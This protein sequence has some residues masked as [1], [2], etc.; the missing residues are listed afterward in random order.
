MADQ[1]K[2]KNLDQILDSLLA[3]Y[4]DV[5]PRPGLETRIVAK[6]RDHANRSN[7]W[8][9]K[10]AWTWSG[11]AVAA[12]AVLVLIVG[13]ELPIELPRQPVFHADWSLLHRSAPAVV[14]AARVN[15]KR[16]QTHEENAVSIATADTRPEVFP[17]PSPL[18]DQ[19][20]LMLRYL[21]R[22]TKQEIIAQ[23]HPDKPLETE[24]PLQ[25]P[26]QSPAQTEFKN[27]TR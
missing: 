15:K 20:K 11:T 7:G 21:A 26:M 10:W 1:E 18:S 3:V 5:E 19:E 25:Q 23:S 17:T 24:E 13:L 6:L 27:S 12:L 22:T 4:S 9:W 14:E 2:D 16:T 8:N